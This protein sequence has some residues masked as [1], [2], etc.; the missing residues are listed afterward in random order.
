[1]K[2]LFLHIRTL[3]TILFLLISSAD[4]SITVKTIE[5]EELLLYEKS[6]ALV[7]E[8]SDY[9]NFIRLPGAKQDVQEV[10][11]ALERKGFIVEL[12]LNL[13]G[14]EFK[15]LFTDFAL[16]RGKKE[17]TRMLFYYA[18]H[19]ATLPMAGNDTMGYLATSSTFL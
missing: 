12:A 13:T 9:Q 4:A 17:N 1:M 3:I 14:K 16:N 11:K 8:N 7:V 10:A 15:T 2:T 18:G 6:Y 5:G 19:G